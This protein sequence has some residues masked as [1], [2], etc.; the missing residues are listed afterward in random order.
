MIKEISS[1]F[2]FAGNHKIDLEV[3]AHSKGAVV[4]GDHQLKMEVE[5]ITEVLHW[6]PPPSS[7]L[8]VLFRALR[9]HQWSKNLLLFTFISS[10]S[11]YRSHQ[12]LR[13]V[14]GLLVLL[15]GCV[16]GLSNQRYI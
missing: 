16:F 15:A 11:V 4:V 1:D 5:K 9:A 10:P 8:R 6:F 14:L 7:Y 3:W 2:Y 13:Y 12:D